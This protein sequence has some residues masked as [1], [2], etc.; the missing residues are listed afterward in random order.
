MRP[1]V[2]SLLFASAVAVVGC[3]GRGGELGSGA[4]AAP[5]SAEAGRD[6]PG[7]HALEE[8]RADAPPPVQGIIDSDHHARLAGAVRELAK[9]HCG[10]CHQS[11]RPT[12][13]GAALA[14]FDLDRVDW[15]A[16]MADHQLDAF[17]QRAGRLDRDAVGAFLDAE[18]GRRQSSPSGPEVRRP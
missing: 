4:A 17:R 9:P 2:M 16:T 12:A 10:E 3:A 13:K 11:S 8:I 1:S 7:I 18:S 5:R 14:V 15:Y 6:V